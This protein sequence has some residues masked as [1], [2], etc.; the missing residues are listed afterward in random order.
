M[1][2][3]TLVLVNFGGPRSI[4]EVTLFLTTL[5]TDSDVI[6]T[7]FPRFFE[8]WFFRRVALKRTKKAEAEYQLIGGSRPFLKI[9]RPLL[10]RYDPE[11]R[12]ESSRFIDI[13]RQPILSFSMKLK[14]MLRMNF[15][16]FL[17]TLSLVM[18]RQGV[19]PDF[20]RKI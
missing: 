7:P 19:L 12:L 6:R 15:W 14:L 17:C 9:P 10:R 5:L 16:Y 3:N 8:K 13:C 18:Q 2:T 20:F 4:E 1:S 11:L